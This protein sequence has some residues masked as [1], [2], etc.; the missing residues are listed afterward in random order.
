MRAGQ[1]VLAGAQ[2][3]LEGTGLPGSPELRGL[4]GGAILATPA[5][6]AQRDSALTHRLQLVAF[7]QRQR[8]R[9]HAACPR[10]PLLPR[11]FLQAACPAA[12]N[13]AGQIL[14][15]LNPNQAG[16]CL[17]LFSLTLRAK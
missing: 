15:L 16:N 13:R 9:L 8:Q 10:R 17:A 6:R 2:L 11:P 4:S 5:R 1:G 12:L 7:P 14:Q 3:G